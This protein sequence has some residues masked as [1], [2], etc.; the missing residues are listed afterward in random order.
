MSLFGT[1]PTDSALPN[2]RTL[3]KSLFSDEPTPGTASTSS[4]FADDGG[5]AS[6]WSMPAPKKAA[7]RE[8]VKTLLPATDVPESYVDAYD[9]M[10][11]SGQRVGSGVGLTGVKKILGTSGLATADQAAIL[12]LLIPGGHESANGLGRSEFNVLL[13]L[14]GLAQEGEDISLDGV[15]ERRKSIVLSI[16]STSRLLLILL[17]IYRYR[18]LATLIN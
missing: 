16:D 7:R 11:N 15:D 6:P 17:Q 1:S 4:L 3:S 10:L 13:A 9:N 8:L 18:Q 2:S 5:D 12:H 14:I